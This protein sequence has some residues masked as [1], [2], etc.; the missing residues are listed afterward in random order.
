MSAL[1]H[2]VVEDGECEICD[3]PAVPFD[4]YTD[5]PY[6]AQHQLE[7]W[8]NAALED[9]TDA[10]MQARIRHEVHR[11]TTRSFRDTICEECEPADFI[12]TPPGATFPTIRACIHCASKMW[13]NAY[14]LEYEEW[15]LDLY[16]EIVEQP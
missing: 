13:M 11:L 1:N 14:L 6:C 3:E 4:D 8:T 10:D 12:L 5:L 16:D 9:F 7:Y 15:A 2:V